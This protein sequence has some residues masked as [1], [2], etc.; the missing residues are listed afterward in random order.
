MSSSNPLKT[1]LALC[2]LAALGAC[3]GAPAP[4][5]PAQA[6]EAGPQAVAAPAPTAAPAA[7]AAEPPA[8]PVAKRVPHPLEAHGQIRADDYYW[9]RDREDPEVVA[10]LE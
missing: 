3:Q 6:P 5:T 2:L 1:L 10:Y 7:A 4:E 9:L 8:P